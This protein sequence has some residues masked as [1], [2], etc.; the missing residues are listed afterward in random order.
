MIFES[1]RLAPTA[2]QPGGKLYRFKLWVFEACM[3]IH[4]AR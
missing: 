1:K 3:T 4:A 2:Q